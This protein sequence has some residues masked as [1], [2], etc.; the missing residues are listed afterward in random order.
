MYCFWSVSCDAGGQDTQALGQEASDDFSAV[1]D[2]AS[3]E[4]AVMFSTDA[5][6]RRKR[7]C[8]HDQ[9]DLLFNIASE[10]VGLTKTYEC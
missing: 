2:A 4:K 3:K 1:F 10:Q 6:G 5:W 9:G 8:L 7:E